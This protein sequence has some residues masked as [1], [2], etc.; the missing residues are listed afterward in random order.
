M[1]APL[2]STHAVPPAATPHDRRTVLYVEDNASNLCLV[3]RILA[4]RPEVRLLS[5]SAGRTGLAL[6]R[7]HLPDLILL[8]L[9]LPDIH[10]DEVL[11]Q[12]R[13]DAQ[14]R[15]IPVIMISADAMPAQIERLRALGASH[16]M[17]KPIEVR[18]LLAIVDQTLHL[19]H[20]PAS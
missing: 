11:R 12:L 20:D 8:D 4:R 17:T 3:E 10:G 13:A 16:Y 5:A 1:S 6:A 14:T 19:N 7:Q 15:H 9:Q 18:Q 2:P